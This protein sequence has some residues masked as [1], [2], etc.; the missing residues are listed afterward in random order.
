MAYKSTLSIYKGS[1]GGSRNSTVIGSLTAGERAGDGAATA[2]TDK[3]FL[4]DSAFLADRGCLGR[5]GH[6]AGLQ[7]TRR[8]PS[9]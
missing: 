3:G 7:L 4:S 6:P 1:K 2:E 8:G 9:V 5:A